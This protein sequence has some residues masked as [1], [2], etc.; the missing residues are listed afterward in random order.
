[1]IRVDLAFPAKVLWPNGSEGNR[2]AKA[3]ARRRA[4]AD[5]WGMTYDAPSSVQRAL[6]ASEGILAV[7]LT[8]HAKPK[9][10]LPDRDNCI[11]ACK[12]Y[13]DG[14]ADALGIDD[15]RFA[16]PTVE[17]AQPRNG[18]FVIEVSPC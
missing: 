13:L 1:M 15:K 14:I 2:F 12:S 8:V 11:A 16:A 5:A 6:A 10:K 7:K 4:R 9:G 3:A 17:F 18:R